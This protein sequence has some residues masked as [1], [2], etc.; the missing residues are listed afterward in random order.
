MQ[1]FMGL[2]QVSEA[3]AVL[4][5]SEAAVSITEHCGPGKTPHLKTYFLEVESC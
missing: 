3:I 2:V 1:S 5:G 4:P